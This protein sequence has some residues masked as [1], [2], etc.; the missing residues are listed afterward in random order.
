[1]VV[2]PDGHII[3]ALGPF[4]ANV[5]DATI[6][7]HI[8]T[9]LR[10]I[11]EE[12][13]VILVDRGFRDAVEHLT[14]LG[15]DVRMPE[16]NPRGT[17]TVDQANRTRLVTK[18]RY[19]VEVKNGHLKQCFRLFDKVWPNHSIPHMMI[20]FRI[21]CAIL[22]A[23][24][25]DIESDVRD[26]ME[27]A[28]SMLARMDKWNHLSEL[29]AAQNLNR[30]HAAFEPID[31]SSLEDFPQ[32]SEADLRSITL[33]SYQRRLV[34]SYYA[35][36]LKTNGNWEIEVCKHVGPLSLSSHSI[37]VGDPMLIRGRMQSRHRNSI[38]YFLYILVNRERGGDEAISDYCCSCP[39]GPRTVG[40]CSHITT[41]LWYL[42]LG[43]YLP[44]ILI[45]A[46]FLEFCVEPV[47][48]EQ[49]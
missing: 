23:Y 41:V 14:A 42:G 21:A 38:R 30:R 3:D 45:P 37:S 36:H 27:I 7:R 49:Q 8:G 32:L 44:E 47:G 22:N 18:C 48:Q 15:L 28:E 39:S 20:D 6:A 25:P 9:D 13:D 10:S 4:A 40:I 43:Q 2:S 33:G 34:L 24:H 11:L 17:L 5:N 46:E 16:S 26:G 29:V 31:G 12:G 19:I 35:E 1:M